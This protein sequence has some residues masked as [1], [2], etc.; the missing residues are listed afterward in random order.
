MESIFRFDVLDSTNTKAISLAREGADEAVVIAAKQTGGRGRMGSSFLSPE[1]GLY[2]SVLTSRLKAGDGVL[3]LT[4][5]A[6]LAVRR[7][8]CRTYGLSCGIKYPNDLLLEGRKLCG[9]L[10]ESVSCGE[11]FS[12][13]IGAGI[14]VCSDVPLPEDAPAYPPGSLKDFSR[15]VMSVLNKGCKT[16]GVVTRF[17]LKK[18][19]NSSGIQFSQAQFA[20]DRKLTPEEYASISR[21]SE[22]V[23]T[24][25]HQVGYDLDEPPRAEVE[26]P[27][28]ENE[29]DW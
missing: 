15:Y 5:A 3:A 18:A 16:N 11:R 14:N 6:A 27:D 12:V 8:I 22:Q 29:P 2:L 25:S 24:L 26:K 1:G 19:T 28:I 23:K 21:M 13:V 10:C 7:S 4:P 9:I 20:I 17:T